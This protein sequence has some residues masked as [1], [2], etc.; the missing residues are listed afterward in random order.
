MKDFKTI[1]EYSNKLL[2]IANKIWLLAIG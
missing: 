2:D 1:K